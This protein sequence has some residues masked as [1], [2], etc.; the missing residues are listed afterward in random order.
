M[1]LLFIC[2]H[3][4]C[5][6][7]IA[8]AVT[9]QYG[10]GA[11]EARS[12]GSQPSGQVH[13]LSIKYLQ[14][15][16]ID[17]SGLQSQSWDEHEAWQPDAVITVCDQAAAEQCPVWFGN[18]LKAHWGLA[19]P[20]R[21]EGDDDQVAT[22]FRQTIATLKSRIETLLSADSQAMQPAEL[23]ALLNTMGKK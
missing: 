8:E 1:K 15:A 22:A 10:Q 14:Q 7:I 13:P 23:L 20:S 21:L 4:R 9:N 18:S 17:T 5:R 6:S 12:A 2:T 3:N 16:A 11:L 19:D